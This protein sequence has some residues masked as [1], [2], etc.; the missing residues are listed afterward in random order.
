MKI[1]LV[2]YLIAFSAFSTISAVAQ[3]YRIDWHTINGGG[4]TSSGGPYSLSGT[5]GQPDA[6]TLGGGDYVL[7]GGFWGVIVAIQQP[8]APILHRNHRERP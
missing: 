4:G 5:I 6:G 1:R 2:L 7:E 3:D 8:G